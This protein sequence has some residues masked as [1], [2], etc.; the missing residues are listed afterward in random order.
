MPLIS[1]GNAACHFNTVYSNVQALRPSTTAWGT[2]ITPGSNTM[3]TATSLGITATKAC[4]AIA[5]Y[6]SNSATSAAVRCGLTNIMMDP[7][8]GTTYTTVLLPYLASGCAGPFG[9]VTTN[10]IFY[11]FPIYIPAGA[12]IA[13]QAQANTTLTAFPVAVWLFTDPSNPET[14]AYGYKC[15]AIG[16]VTATSQGTGVTSGTTADGTWTSLG[17]STQQNWW[18][19]QGVQINNSVITAMAYSAQISADNNAT[20][21]KLIT[22]DM[23]INTSST[24]QI[25]YANPSSPNRAMCSVASGTAIYGRMQC[26]GTAV[27]GTTMIAY[28]VE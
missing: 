17:T 12:T 7:A 2:S 19:Q 13:A 21:P 10:G 11:Y 25:G 4:Y 26:S 16:A 9:G 15:E 6:I 28:G 27:T 20:T 14:L 23:I 22:D 8:G 5:V 1:P 18:W 24:E 3:G